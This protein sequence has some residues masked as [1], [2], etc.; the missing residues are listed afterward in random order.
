MFNRIAGAAIALAACASS[1]GL[2]VG[3]AHAAGAA[4]LGGG[5]GIFVDEGR[6]TLATIGRDAGGRLV[7]F[8]AGHCGDAGTAV[9]SEAAPDAGVVG[10]FA[11]SNK[12][13]DYAVIV[14]DPDKVVPVN[15]I[16]NT[17]ITEVGAPAQFPEIACKEGRTTGQTCGLI[18]GELFGTGGWTWTQVCVL[19]G[20][21][22]GPV[23]VGTKL[24]GLVTG[25]LNVP[26]LG[27]QVGPSM[28]AIVNDADA[29]G[30]AGAGF[31]P[32]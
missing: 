21:S 19:P 29:G 9:R 10:S 26:C 8:T 2:Q 25:Y 14:F 7:G 31:H 30:G 24:I 16:G 20:D 23:V 18:Y 11:Y 13:M 4:V 28:S 5:S 17:T 15:R 3:T 32:I 27:P 22:G 1:I 12:D 6:C